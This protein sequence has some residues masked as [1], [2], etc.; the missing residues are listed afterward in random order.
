[1][2]TTLPRRFYADPAFYQRE[3]ERFFF[4]R[5]ICAGRT[6]QIPNRGD[7]FVRAIADESVI[8]TRDGAGEVRALFNVCRHRG[9]RICES[10]RRPLRRA[11][12]VPV[13]CVDVRPDRA[14]ARGAAHAGGVLSRTVRAYV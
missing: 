13:P 1:M 4:G 7:Y 2:H 5:W 9:T 6:E 11:N 10:D 12:P 14:V 3:L 8:I